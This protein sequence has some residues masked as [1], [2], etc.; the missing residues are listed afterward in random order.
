MVL[1]TLLTGKS[2]TANLIRTYLPLPLSVLSPAPF[3]RAS[4]RPSVPAPER[5]AFPNASVVSRFPLASASLAFEG[6]LMTYTTTPELLKTVA[7]VATATATANVTMA[8]VSRT[9]MP[10]ATFTGTASGLVP[11]VGA[12]LAGVV[13]I[14]AFFA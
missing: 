13:G 6:D 5:V 7:A 12:A 14:A 11:G 10:I 1:P 9:G 4:L 8:T 2:I 3:D